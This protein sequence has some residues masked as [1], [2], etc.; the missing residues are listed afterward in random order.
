M[1]PERDNKNLCDTCVTLVL[2]LCYTCVTLVLHLCDTGQPDSTHRPTRF[3]P[4]ANQIPPT[5][6]PDS[7]HRPLRFHSEATQIPLKGHSDST[8]RPLKMHSI[9]GWNTMVIQISEIKKNRTHT[10]IKQIV[11]QSGTIQRNEYIN[12]KQQRMNYNNKHTHKTQ[13]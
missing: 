9:S 4:Q 8:Q 6:H 12:Q 11:T 2:H 10:F 13:T 3:H 1:K 7:T 5:G